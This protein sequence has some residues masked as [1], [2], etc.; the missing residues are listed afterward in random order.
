MPK[1]SL[2]IEINDFFELLND[3]NPATKGAFSLQRIKLLP[4]FFQI[5]NTWLVNSFYKYYGKDIKR[6]KG[7]LL[8]AVD[9]ST[10][11][12]VEKKEVIDY[13]GTKTNQFGSTPM[14]RI[15]QI[16][17]VLN[18]ITVMSE[19]SPST[20]SEK[21]IITKHID[22]LYPD[23]LTIFD[24]G[25]PGYEIMYLMLNQERP[26][27]FVMRCKVDFNNEVRC[28][29]AS[30]ASSKIVELRPTQLVINELYKKGYLI[31]KHT[32]IKVRMVKVKLS[33]GVIEVLL[34]SL[35]DEQEY[36][37]EDLKYV[38]G[39]HWGIE[40]SYGT[41]KNQLQLEQ[42]SGHRVICIQ[43]DFYASVFVSNLQ[44]LI[45]KQC[46]EYVDEINLKR[47]HKYKIN[48]NV[49]WGS[50]KYNI[51]RLFFMHDSKELLIKLQHLFERSTEPIRP[52][53]KYERDKKIK[54]RRGKFRTVTNYK[55]AI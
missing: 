45:N 31:K 49:S 24:R 43:Q 4:I 3:A 10:V 34:T 35:Y 51:V 29:V 55:R 1:R 14:A 15:M 42:A 9:G 22:N 2:S 38:Y 7:F 23:S 20:V 25:F 28:F 18:D 12:L 48:R 44:S 47:K 54:F 32:T 37:E 36:T 17:D 19:I 50:L 27:H 30:K 21:A 33:T 11:N 46:Q 40:T 53:R 26:R 52:N 39:L 41:Q 16:Y 5:W 13:F 6:W 8:L